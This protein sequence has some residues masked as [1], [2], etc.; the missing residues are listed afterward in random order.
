MNNCTLI[1]TS[2][3][4]KVGEQTESFPGAAFNKNNKTDLRGSTPHRRTV[5]SKN[6]N[7][8][9]R[10]ILLTIFASE[11]IQALCD[12]QLVVVNARNCSIL[13]AGNIS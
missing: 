11:Q 8:E 4:A 12:L 7:N 6:W 1:L 3:L 2:P 13:F 5:L 9:K 10:V